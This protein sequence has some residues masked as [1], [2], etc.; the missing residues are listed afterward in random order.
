MWVPTHESNKVGTLFLCKSEIEQT[1]FTTVISTISHEIS[2]AF[3]EYL[4]KQ[5]ESDDILQND[6]NWLSVYNSRLGE[7]TSYTD[8]YKK[9]DYRYKIAPPEQD[10]WSMQLFA[11]DRLN[12]VVDEYAGSILKTVGFDSYVD[13]K[14]KITISKWLHRKIEASKNIDDLHQELEKL[15]KNFPDLAS[16]I[17]EIILTKDVDSIL[18]EIEIIEDKIKIANEKLNSSGAEEKKE[19]SRE[20]FKNKELK[21]VRDN[22]GI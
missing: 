13:F 21:R 19:E 20:E 16:R 6:K 10:A 5:K 7:Q 2:H 22:L 17:S 18:A 15:G 4:R 1:S 12:S 8:A 3:Q 14:E 11:P 9:S